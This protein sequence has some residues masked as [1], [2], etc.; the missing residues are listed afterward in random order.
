MHAAPAPPSPAPMQESVV[1]FE[2]PAA[3][4]KIQAFDKLDEL[5]ELHEPKE[6]AKSGI[7]MQR[8][9][10]GIAASPAIR[11]DAYR[12]AEE[13][14]FEIAQ[15]NVAPQA[16]N[17]APGAL[18]E[19]SGFVSRGR[20][21]AEISS[22]V[23]GGLLPRL[24]DDGLEILFWM[25]KSGKIVGCTI[26]MDVLRDRIAGAI[27]EMLNELRILTVLDET[28]SPIVA[29]ETESAPDWRRPF[30]AR[31]ISS[32]LPRWEVGAW[33]VDPG[34]M[35]SRAEYAQRTVWVLVAAFFV[36]LVIGSLAL[37]RA[38]FA[39]MRIAR[40]K[41]TFVANVSHELKTPLTSI[42]L[43]AE[44]LLSGRQSDEAKRVEYLRTMVSETERLSNLVDNVLAF[45]RRDGGNDKKFRMEPLMLGEITRD[46]C[47]QMEPYLKRRGFALKLECTDNLPVQGDREALRQVLMNIMSNAEKYSG[48]VREIDILC[49]SRDSTAFVAVADRGVGVTKKAARKIFNEFYRA[50][51]S[52]SAM[53]SGA[54]LGL[55]IARGIARVHGGDVTY[56]PRRGGGS[57][58][59]LTLPLAASETEA[60]A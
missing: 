21:F 60:K 13:E 42:R 4:E 46:T 39:E 33:L 36:L 17:I 9:I 48:D 18:D 50:D 41:T 35:T 15:R 38:V 47:A 37:I 43:F 28:G 26:D 10:S 31:E 2:P 55:S 19:R 44:L 29:P 16:Q 1:S 53:R 27:P 3:E 14:G 58:F 24:T 32:E 56:E 5:D 49:G 40:Q 57:I 6:V 7:A 59:K 45:S 52:L 23:S 22:G 20:T 30:V 8:A 34:L 12:Q 51:D 54:G 25:K 11:E